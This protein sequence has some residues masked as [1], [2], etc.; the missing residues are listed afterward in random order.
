MGIVGLRVGIKLDNK[1]GVICL[2]AHSAE[3]CGLEKHACIHRLL[4]EQA[5]IF[6]W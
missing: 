2:G 1:T 6:A 4:D 3:F 5:R